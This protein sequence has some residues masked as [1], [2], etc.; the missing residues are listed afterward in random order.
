M[1]NALAVAGRQRIKKDRGR[2]ASLSQQSLVGHV[3]WGRAAAPQL[4]THLW[5]EKLALVGADR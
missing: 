4:Q 5:R 1:G 3:T 2:G